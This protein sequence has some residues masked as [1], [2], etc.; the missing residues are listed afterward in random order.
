MVAAEFFNK[1]EKMLNHCEDNKE[2][3]AMN[4]SAKTMRKLLQINRVQSAALRDIQD[5]DILKAH[6]LREI[7]RG[8]ICACDS[9]TVKAD[10]ENHRI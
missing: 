5:G 1:I 4:I 8:T 3:V 2:S 10:N 6:E 7:A 9:L